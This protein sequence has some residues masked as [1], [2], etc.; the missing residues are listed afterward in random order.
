[1]PLIEAQIVSPIPAGRWP[2]TIV[3]M[4]YRHAI[5]SGNPMVVVQ[6]ELDINGKLVTHNAYMVIGGNGA[7][8]FAAFMAACGFRKIGLAYASPKTAPDFELDDL[9]GTRVWCHADSAG[10]IVF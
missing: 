8:G 10:F 3:G 5:S 9:I 7:T 4:D 1:M 2:A 6:L